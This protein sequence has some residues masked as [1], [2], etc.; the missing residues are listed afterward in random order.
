MPHLSWN[1]VRDHAVRF[2]RDPAN[3]DATSESGLILKLFF[4]VFG[5]C[6]AS[7]GEQ[8]LRNDFGCIG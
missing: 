4:S 1:E 6:R 8:L 5:L 3:R 7:L 2:S